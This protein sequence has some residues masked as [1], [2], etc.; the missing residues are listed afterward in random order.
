[1]A[2]PFFSALDPTS[3]KSGITYC[4]AGNRPCQGKEMLDFTVGE[5]IA[6]AFNS[7]LDFLSGLNATYNILV[8]RH[9]D[10]YL[11][12]AL[13]SKGGT[14][15]ALDYLI[16]PLVAR[17][18]I[19]DSYL[20]ERRNSRLANVLAWTVAVPLELVRFAAAFALTLLLVPVIALV[21]IVKARLP[22]QE[23]DTNAPAPG[24]TM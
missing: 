16:L 21:H 20:S 2:L 24:F 7:D 23:L 17:K 5:C 14:K 8:G 19:S 15:G 9:Y 11:K 4:L 6:D 1:M 10:L 13:T 3:K 12:G 18:L 22:K